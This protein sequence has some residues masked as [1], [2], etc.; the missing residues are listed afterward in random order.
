[1]HREAPGR[2]HEHLCTQRSSNLEYKPGSFRF[3]KQWCRFCCNHHSGSCCSR[4]RRRNR[5]R[6]P[7]LKDID[8]FHSHRSAHPNKRFHN[9]HSDCCWCV[10]SHKNRYRRSRP[11]GTG[12]FRSH[13][14]D[15]PNKHCHN[16]HS[17]CCLSVCSRKNCHMLLGRLCKTQCIDRSD[18]RSRWNT[19]FR[20]NHS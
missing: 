1:M 10:C 15:H 5:C 19:S 13:K 16:H 3:G 7:F 6:T 17:G 14:T 8:S 2:R 18:R 11:R 4:C 12:S 20:K 9:H